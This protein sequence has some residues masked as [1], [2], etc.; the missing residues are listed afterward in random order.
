M[1]AATHRNLEQMVRE[2]RFRADL[3]FRLNVLYALVRV[4]C[5]VLFAYR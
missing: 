2:E 3:L 4:I 1:I 5:W